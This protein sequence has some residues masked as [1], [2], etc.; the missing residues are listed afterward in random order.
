M[1][2]PFLGSLAAG[3]EVDRP[4]PGVCVST[5]RGMVINFRTRSRRLAVF[6]QPG[7]RSL[8]SRYPDRASVVRWCR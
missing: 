2:P 6:V 4:R 3:H 7:V 5:A 1:L 8:C